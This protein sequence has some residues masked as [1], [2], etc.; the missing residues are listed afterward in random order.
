MRLA[1]SSIASL[2]RDEPRPKAPNLPGR[3]ERGQLV[4]VLTERVDNA[5]TAL[6]TLV[7]NLPT[8]ARNRLHC[9]LSCALRA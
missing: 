6:P 5:K 9:H 1:A 4:D 3:C 2:I 7:H 8:P